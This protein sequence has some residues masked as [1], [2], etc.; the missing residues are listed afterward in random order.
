MAGDQLP[1]RRPSPSPS[2]V[3]EYHVVNVLGDGGGREMHKAKPKVLRA[4][5]LRQVYQ[6][7]RTTAEEPASP[8]FPPGTDVTFFME[9]GVMFFE[10]HQWRPIPYWQYAK[11]IAEL[12]AIVDDGPARSACRQRLA[13]LSG[14]FDMYR[15]LNSDLEEQLCSQSASDVFSVHKVDT[16]VRLAT[17]MNAHD[18]M[19][20]VKRKA[21]E[22]GDA[23]VQVAADGTPTTLRQL[24]A[25]VGISN[26]SFVSVE[27]TGL[28]P[29]PCTALFRH[30][31]IFSKR[32]P[33]G[34]DQTVRLLK[35]FLKIHN[36]QKGQYFAELV[37]P[38]LHR[39]QGPKAIVSSQYI[40][41]IM[42][43]SESEWQDLADWLQ[44]HDLHTPHNRWVIRIPCVA[45]IREHFRCSTFQQQLDHIFAPLW[46]ASV[47]P[48]A[49]PAMDLLLRNVV[50]FNVFS[51]EPHLNPERGNLPLNR[52]PSEWPWGDPPPDSL[53]NY[54][55]WA[56]L[57]S[58]NHFR[59]LQG[60]NTFDFVP[61]CGEV[62]ATSHLV[63]AFLLARAAAG[64][65]CMKAVPVLQYLY[66]LAQVGIYC[67]PL[68]SNAECI[69]YKNNPFP[70]F[71][72]RG[73]KVSLCTVDPLHYHH[74]REPVMEEYGAAAKIFKLS[75]VDMC[76]V[77]RN[78]V[79]TSSFEEALKAEWLRVSD[80]P[81][82]CR[83][84]LMYRQSTL[85]AEIAV[86]NAP[87]PPSFG[88]VCY[89]PPSFLRHHQNTEYYIPF[90]RFDINGPVEIPSSGG[91]K[92]AVAL[93]TLL[94]VRFKYVWQPPTAPWVA[95][96]HPPERLPK[97]FTCQ[98]VNG[99]MRGY[100]KHNVPVTGRVPSF[101]E[102]TKDWLEFQ[103]V[104]DDVDVKTLAFWRLLMLE[105]KFD[106]YKAINGADEEEFAEAGEHRDFYQTHKVD[107]HIHMAAAMTGKRLLDFIVNKVTHHDHD[108]VKQGPNGP[109]TLGEMFKA[110]QV[111][112]RGL[113]VNALDVQADSTLWERFDYFNAKY[114]PMGNSELREMFLKTDNYM[115]GR[116]FAEIVKGVFADMEKDVFTFAENRISIYGKHA[117]EW[118]KLANWFDVHGM[119]H[120]HN[121]WM[122]Q[123]PRTYAFLFESGEVK[124]FA[125]LLTNIFTPLWEVS[126]DP[127][128]DPKLSYFM[129]Q[130]SGFDCVD[131][132]AVMDLPGNEVSPEEW[133]SGQNPSYH[134]WLYHLWGN[135]RALNTFRAS[136][137]QS[138]Y[139]FRPHCG[140]SGPVSHL[141]TGFLLADGI[142]HGI[143][144]RHSPPL[145]YLCFLAQ[146]PIAMSPLSNNSL[147]LDIHS[148][149]FPSFFSK[150]L[151]VSLSTD[152]PLQFHNTQEPLVEEYSIASKIWKLD[153]T[154]M[155]EIARN[156]VRQSGFPHHL[157]EKWLGKFYFLGSTLGNR[158]CMSHVADI[159]VAFRFEVY[160]DELRY[161]E[162]VQDAVTFRRCVPTMEEEDHLLMQICGLSREEYLRCRS[163]KIFTEGN[164]ILSGPS[165]GVEVKGKAALLFCYRCH[166]Q[167]TLAVSTDDK[168]PSYGRLYWRCL[169][170]QCVQDGGGLLIYADDEELL[171]LQQRVRATYHTHGS[172]AVDVSGSCLAAIFPKSECKRLHSVAFDPAAHSPHKHR[173]R[174]M[175][176][177][178]SG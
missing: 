154:D 161:L 146:I 152:D 22:D 80:G 130:F 49:A 2:P 142:S 107:T 28:M 141:V 140:E 109:V 131:N 77:A 12:K 63:S 29:S 122:I 60:M 102:F 65:S 56:N 9:D 64:G 162:R 27:T 90:A 172:D 26:P 50:A 62:E 58:L 126:I 36:H 37:K 120:H 124:S 34:H 24:M 94:D 100:D 158:P 150:G 117:S 138:T 74:T 144:L 127:S 83:Y 82:A 164:Y 87:P 129:D 128:R 40:V 78:S 16:S 108:L 163:H 156:S 157:K 89:V 20:F 96:N 115:G 10:G 111:D 47:H 61:N 151:N 105:R 99:V 55:I 11:D 15:Y 84:R 171:R 53:F 91:K 13:I 21:G 4:L 14:K 167:L 112:V 42:G 116:Y 92:A 72:K 97:E 123:I 119:Y 25:G 68:C 118:S 104:I 7:C 165:T 35:L 67:S 51:D 33:R 168:S 39:T 155:C 173:H 98:L 121:C 132:E 45:E 106:V 137:G 110:L 159:R 86:L 136:R 73:L 134:Y 43:R 175:P 48:E 69:T 149:P 135:I 70:E 3:N 54:Y 93:K 170:E 75:V 76:E 81:G 143:N 139:T 57:E 17:S 41:P 85:T 31:D 46:R 6:R 153:P 30:F 160:H 145:Q 38:L 174:R 88:P 8:A 1:R 52:P 177:P 113:T 147:F 32:R 5:E 79:E 176:E 66:Y 166:M 95:R 133:T 23:V 148:N 169:S 19:E 101:A 59:Q 178:D 114:R 18:L 44:K 125:E 103:R 71:L